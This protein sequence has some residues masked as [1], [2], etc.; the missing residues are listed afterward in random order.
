MASRW[1]K[2]NQAAL[3]AFYGEPGPAVSQQLVS[4]V[5]PFKMFYAGTPVARIMF[6]RLAAPSLKRALD[7]IWDYYERDQQKL[8]K[9]GV[10]KY[11]GAYNHRK[12]RGS[13]TKWSNH[14]YGA[15]IDLDAE[16]NGFG[17][18]HGLMPTPVVCA[19]KA[20]GFSWGGDYKNR[21]DPM[22][23]ELCDR[24]E[25]ERTF[26]QWLAFY[27]TPLKAANKPA[28]KPAKAAEVEPEA[29]PDEPE[30]AVVTVDAPPAKQA[31]EIEASAEKDAETGGSW[32]SRKWKHVTGWFGGGSA[33]GVL[34]YL[35]DPWV[36]VA[37][38]GVVVV[39]VVAFVLFMGP[40]N[41]RAWIRKQVT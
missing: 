11:S 10:S 1:P 35:T 26:E 39:V 40:G 36:I 16:H 8:D 19:F 24:G 27:K 7:T 25:P 29:G 41:V 37:I 21:T 12:V 31:R 20:A 30:T 4:V 5:P 6:H 15:A 17:T 22:H 13:E 38:G 9:L 2:D 28:P 18:G 23:F 34:G 32:L 14:A 3:I 33:V